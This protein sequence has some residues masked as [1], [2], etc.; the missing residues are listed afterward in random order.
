M[1]RGDG[2]P[3]T[4]QDLAKREDYFGGELMLC[5]VCLREEKSDRFR[6][7]DW[8][9]CEIDGVPYYACPRHFPPNGSDSRKF[10]AAYRQVFQRAMER[11]RLQLQIDI[12]ESAARMKQELH[13]AN[14]VDVDRVVREYVGDAKRVRE[15]CQRRKIVPRELG[16]LELVT[17]L[18][19]QLAALRT[20][21]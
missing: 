2:R 9:C 3:P 14:H 7:S 13:P 20:N 6:T 16:V 12:V 5:V 4:D 15:L 8:R 10:E 21:H 1:W 11:R 18:R 17:G 19:M